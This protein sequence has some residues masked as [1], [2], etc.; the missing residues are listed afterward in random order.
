MNIVS[1]LK[2]LVR[3]AAV[4]MLVS[5]VAHAASPNSAN[6]YKLD[7][8]IKKGGVAIVN[9]KISVAFGK[10]AQI[11]MSKQGVGDENYRIQVTAQPGEPAGNG[12]KT[13]RL[14]FIVLEQVSGAWV[15]L[16]EPSMVA[17]DGQQASVDVN[18]PA[19]AFSVS[20]T[21]TSGFDDRAASLK[22]DSCP[23]LEAPLVKRPEK[24]GGI[25]MGIHQ[26]PDCCSAG[27]TDG[28]GW[29]MT[30]CGAIECCA[31]GTCCRPR[32]SGG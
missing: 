17:Y 21:A 12:K 1:K 27:C 25:I 18:G 30:C 22:S 7:V 28:S 19:G 23:T 6:S 24:S 5:S 2:N 9:P 16:G 31:C 10:P 20:A 8:T 3:I 26:D 11:T 29:T 13:V 32:S 14:D 15:V 4:A